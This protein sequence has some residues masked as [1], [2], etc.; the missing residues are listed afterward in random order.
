MEVKLVGF[1]F[2][3]LFTQPF[4]ECNSHYNTSFLL[5]CLLPG[6]SWCGLVTLGWCG[7]I[8]VVRPWILCNTSL[9]TPPVFS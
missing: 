6:S 5:I 4:K 7:L 3:Y 2:S 1:E 9:T 8:V